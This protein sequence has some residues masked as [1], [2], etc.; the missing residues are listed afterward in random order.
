MNRKAIRL[1]ARAL[2]DEYTE[3]PLG[4]WKDDNANELDLNEIINIAQVNVQIDLFPEIPWYFRKTVLIDITA[5]KREYEI[6]SGKDIDIS[7]FFLFSNIYHNVSGKKPDGLL[8]GEPDQFSELGVEVGELG[9]PRVWSYESAESIAFDPTPSATV[10]NRYKGIYYFE[11]PDLN[12]DEVHSP[13]TNYA[14][15][16]LP[17]PTHILVAIDTARQAHIATKETKTVLDQ[18]YEF[19]KARALRIIGI[20]PSLSIRQ[21]GRLQDRIR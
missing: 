16:A 20:K 15:P 7:D 2:L 13:P 6:G 8:Y 1:Y 4:M 11:L 12:D 10:S 3:K 18:R 19:F 14:I 9:D 5:N 17:K 21:R